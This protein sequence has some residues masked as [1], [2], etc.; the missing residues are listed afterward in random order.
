MNVRKH[1]L[2]GNNKSMLVERHNIGED[3]EAGL[4]NS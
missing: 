1:C 4:L 2:E 3:F